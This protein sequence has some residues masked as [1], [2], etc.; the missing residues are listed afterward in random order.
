MTDHVAHLDYTHLNTFSEYCAAIWLNAA[1]LPLCLLLHDVE[2]RFMAMWLCAAFKGFENSSIGC[3][4]KHKSLHAP[5]L[6]VVHV[7]C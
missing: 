2:V 5:Q 4:K 7:R 3:R 1:N 6:Q